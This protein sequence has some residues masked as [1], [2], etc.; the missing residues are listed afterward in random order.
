MTSSSFCLSI[1]QLK[2]LVVQE[3][4]MWLSFI[5]C[6]ESFLRPHSCILN[7]FIVILVVF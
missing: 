2:I 5:L 1:F 3:I 7:T 4:Y 6:M